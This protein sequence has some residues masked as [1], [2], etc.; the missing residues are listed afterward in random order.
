MR[1]TVGFRI[2]A[3]L[4]LVAGLALSA[5]GGGQPQRRDPEWRARESV[6]STAEHWWWEPVE[7]ACEDDDDCREGESCRTMRLSSCSNCPRGETARICVGGEASPA[8]R[9]SR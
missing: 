4:A 6:P 7:R 9:A 8:R 2:L 3:A 5:C 1:E